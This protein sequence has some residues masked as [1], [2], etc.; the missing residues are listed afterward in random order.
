MLERALVNMQ[1]RLNIGLFLIGIVLALVFLYAN[2]FSWLFDVWM[3][4]K[5][6]SH[7]FLV[8]FIALFLVWIKRKHLATLDPKPCLMAGGIFLF[9]AGLLVVVGRAGGMALAE[10]I[11]FLVMLPGIVLFI[12]GWSSLKALAMPMFYLNFMIPWTEEIISRIHWPF[13]ILSAN[14]GVLLLNCFGYAVFQDEKFIYL[15]T[16]TL[17]VARECSGVRFLTSVIAI[18]IPLVYITQ[19]NW[20]RGAAVI[21]ASVVIT[22]LTNGIRVS[23]AG[24]MASLYGQEMV[25]GPYHIMQGWFVAQVGII[26]L[27]ICNWGIGKIPSKTDNVIYTRWMLNTDLCD[28]SNPRKPANYRQFSLLLIFITC[29]GA[30]IHLLASPLPKPLK[31]ELLKF[32]TSIGKWQGVNSPWIMGETFFPGVEVEL[33]RTY[34]NHNGTE[35]HLYIGYFE[36]Q[37]Q[38]KSI[39]NYRDR[40]LWERVSVIR[41]GLTGDSPLLVNH[42]L[43]T[44]GRT[45]YEA[46]FWYRF[47]SGETTGRYRTKAKGVLDALVHRR[48]NGAVILLAMPINTI[49]EKTMALDELMT[50]IHDVAPVLHDYIP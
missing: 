49:D 11:S 35:V 6:Y 45:S 41:S 33:T 22:I 12:W 28:D 2:A 20:W 10:S 16:I 18:G 47:P 39:V 48:N 27:F 24:V 25:H 7:G 40:P 13:Q 8:P 38:G 15:P 42:S 5:E 36:F 50:F 37:R 21:S 17:E 26:A 1:G 19:R 43:P 29:I 9:F 3:N 30:Y 34:R 23:L 44:I 32:P 46:L 14:L 4:S 31:Q